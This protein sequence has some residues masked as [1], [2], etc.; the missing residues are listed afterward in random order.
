MQHNWWRC[1]VNVQHKG[2]DVK[3][4]ITLIGNKS[5]MICIL[6]PLIAQASSVQCLGNIFVCS[7]QLLVQELKT[8]PFFITVH[9]T[10]PNRINQKMNNTQQPLDPSSPPTVLP[11]T[12]PFIFFDL[13]FVFFFEMPN[14]A[15]W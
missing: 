5:K 1:I 14:W 2:G 3:C 4:R 9:Y 12:L 8:F 15:A 11:P 6:Q 10:T 7:S 13:A